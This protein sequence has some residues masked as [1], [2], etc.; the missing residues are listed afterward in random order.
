MFAEIATILLGVCVGSIA[1]VYAGAKGYLGH[2]KKTAA[3]LATIDSYP[4]K[5][6]QAEVP[7]T[8]APAVAAPAPSPASESS[9]PKAVPSPAP[10]ESVQPA[11][12]PVT[13]S[14]PSSTSF[15]AQ[16]LAKKPTRTYRRRTAPVRSA[17]GVKKP[18]A[19]PK[20]R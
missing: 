20:K 17:A 8:E 13:Y 4:T 12:A 3:A 14:A 19:K 10:Y 5:M 7:A 9:A 11:P 18:L 16:T 15:G 1:V 2:S 6:G